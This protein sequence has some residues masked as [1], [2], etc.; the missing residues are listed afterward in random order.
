[1][2]PLFCY[3]LMGLVWAVASSLSQNTKMKMRIRVF[4]EHKFSP[5]MKTKSISNTISHHSAV[6]K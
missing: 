1:M 4:F 3:G 6:T 5:S 2:K